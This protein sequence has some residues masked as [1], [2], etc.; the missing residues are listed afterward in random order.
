MCPIMYVTVVLPALPA[1]PIASL[2]EM[3]SA[4]ISARVKT[5]TPIPCAAS[6]SGDDLMAPL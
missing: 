6:S 2:S 3:S 1:T 4:S 5:L